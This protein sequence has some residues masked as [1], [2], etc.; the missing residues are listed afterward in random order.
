MP[1]LQ[2]PGE[3]KEKQLATPWP[4]MAMECVGAYYMCA[5]S[6]HR[7][8]VQNLHPSHVALQSDV[9]KRP[10]SHVV[11]RSDVQTSTCKK[12]ARVYE[13]KH[14]NITRERIDYLWLASD[15]TGTS[16]STDY[17]ATMQ[18]RAT[19]LIIIYVYHHRLLHVTCHA[20][21]MYNPVI[22]NLL[23]VKCLH[24]CASNTSASNSSPASSI[25][26]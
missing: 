10:F 5:M 12:N 23:L 4:W 6:G 2:G 25:V 26:Q 18:A 21:T 15:S 7:C 9:Q 3:T 17:A 11:L 24:A 19:T 14:E 8:D 20:G 16:V 13:G 1:R 22:S